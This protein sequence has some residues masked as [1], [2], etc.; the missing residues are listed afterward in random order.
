[1]RELRQQQPIITGRCGCGY[2]PPLD[3]QGPRHGWAK[4]RRRSA[5]V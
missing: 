5:C 3:L 2:R 4:G 1:M